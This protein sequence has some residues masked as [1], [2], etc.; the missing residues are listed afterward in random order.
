MTGR[1]RHL[2]VQIGQVEASPLVSEI[3]TTAE[4]VPV[5]NR[6]LTTFVL[7]VAFDARLGE[8]SAPVCAALGDR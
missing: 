8:R 6:A 7:A 4:R 1:A 5:N 2:G 3:P